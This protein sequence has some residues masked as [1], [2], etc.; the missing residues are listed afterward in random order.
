MKV[1]AKSWRNSFSPGVLVLQGFGE[2]WR[3]RA[4]GLGVLGLNP[5]S[6][7]NHRPRQ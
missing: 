3:L 1:T 7:P 4:L 6:A 2:P 5:S